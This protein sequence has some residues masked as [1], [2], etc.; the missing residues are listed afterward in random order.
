[1]AAICEYKYAT[2]VVRGK[3]GGVAK[4]AEAVGNGV[5]CVWG[6]CGHQTIAHSPGPRKSW[7]E[8]TGIAEIPWIRR[9]RSIRALDS[10]EWESQL[11]PSIKMAKR[12][13]D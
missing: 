6:N 10:K 2:I 8:L 1:M 4:E 9:T 13:F 12:F 11:N 5:M 3:G 7:E